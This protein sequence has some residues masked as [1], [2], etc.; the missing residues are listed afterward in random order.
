MAC[1][2]FLW[3]CKCD[4]WGTQNCNKKWP[5]F[6]CSVDLVRA[7]MQRRRQRPPVGKAVVPADGTSYSLLCTASVLEKYKNCPNTKTAKK[8]GNQPCLQIEPHHLYQNHVYFNYKIQ[9][10][11]Y[12]STNNQK[13]KCVKSDNSEPIPTFHCMQITALHFLL[14]C[15]LCYNSAEKYTNSL[16]CALHLY[17]CT[18]CTLLCIILHQR[19]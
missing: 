18:R 17:Y 3:H 10:M 12:T 15:I 9:N 2:I 8:L 6:I 1:D 14:K 11:K 13:N 4:F 16:C 19:P 7:A 5:I